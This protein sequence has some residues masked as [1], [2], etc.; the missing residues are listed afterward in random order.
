MDATGQNESV[1]MAL[2]FAQN[3]TENGP[4]GFKAALNGIST[5]VPPKPTSWFG[6]R[7]L[8][9]VSEL[10]VRAPGSPRRGPNKYSPSPAPPRLPLFAAGRGAGGCV[11]SFNRQ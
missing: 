7:N 5:F 9:D 2:G 4:F 8:T 6:L 3:S 11:V 1:T 10:P